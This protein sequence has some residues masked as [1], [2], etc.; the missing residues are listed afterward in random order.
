MSART[1]AEGVAEV[2]WLNAVNNTWHVKWG[3]PAPTEGQ[4][5]PLVELAHYEA[6]LAAERARAER[7]EAALREIRDST[8]RNAV[9]LRGMADRALTAPAALA[10]RPSGDG[11]G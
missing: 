10:L 6:A 8:F 1:E 2:I 9:T 11:V 3:G 7:A 5:V 4:A